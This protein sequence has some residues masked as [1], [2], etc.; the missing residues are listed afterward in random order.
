MKVVFVHDW[1]TIAAG[2]EKVATEI[3]DMIQPHAVYS[4]FN[5]MDFGTLNQITQGRG[6][7]TSFLQQIPLASEYYRHLA[8]LYP[9]AVSRLD[10]SEF[11]IIISSS[12][13]AAKGVQ[14]RPGQIH[15]CYCH[16]PMRFAWGLE[17]IY[18][19]QYGFNKGLK[20][21]FAKFLIQRLRTWDEKTAQGVDFF[22]SNSEFV[23]S[24]IQK[25][26]NRNA[27]VIYP[28]VNTAKFALHTQKSEYFFTACRFVDYKNLELIIKAFN[29]LPNH[30]LVIAG[31]GPQEKRLRKLAAPN[32]EF[33][34]WVNEEKLIYY[35]QRAKGFINASIEDFGI[36]GLEAQSTGTPIIALGKG[37]Y[38]ETVIE[39]ETGIFFHREHPEALADAIIR[40]DRL[41]FDP[42]RIRENALRFDREVFRETYLNFFLDKTFTHVEELA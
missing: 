9:R 4:L 33:L 38:T 11:D 12:W 2:A 27:A 32:I 28:P 10:V 20:R 34:G 19:E 24:R 15:I 16:T 26:Y 18:L 22:I 29:R 6:V 17:S 13:V 25:A 39:N 14:K 41:K 1:F 30:R 5:F 40:F 35:M 23:K 21:L 31:Q 8:P 42:L 37:G 36:A 3:I 7:R